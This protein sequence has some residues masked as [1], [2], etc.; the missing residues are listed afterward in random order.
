[1]CLDSG[2]VDSCWHIVDRAEG[3]EDVITI[4]NCSHG[5]MMLWHAPDDSAMT[6]ASISRT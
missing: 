3:E 6:C 4:L 1:M 2:M 5:R